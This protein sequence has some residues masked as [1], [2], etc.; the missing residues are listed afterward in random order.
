MRRCFWFSSGSRM[1]PQATCMLAGRAHE[2]AKK[3]RGIINFDQNVFETKIFDATNVNKIPLPCYLKKDLCSQM[4]RRWK[5]QEY[6][7]DTKRENWSYATEP[8][9]YSMR[10]CVVWVIRC[11]TNKS[12]IFSAWK[13]VKRR[14]V[15]WRALVS[16]QRF[17]PFFF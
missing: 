4:Y 5:T 14:A 12:Q 8:K 2:N 9:N 16:Q 6:K 7:K 13:K 3:V 1:V 15:V 10:V 17:S 11:S